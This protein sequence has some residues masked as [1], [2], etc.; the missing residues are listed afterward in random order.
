M[1]KSALKIAGLTQK[2]LLDL[3]ARR[4]QIQKRLGKTT[5][6]SQW[7]DKT[8][9]PV[10]D[11]AKLTDAEWA[12]MDQIGLYF[13]A[14]TFLKRKA[15]VEALVSNVAS[16]K[17]AMEEAGASEEEIASSTKAA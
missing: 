6:Q 1:N 3:F 11:R 9:I 12:V 7:V 5:A 4:G 16:T 15:K 2:A 8:S 10:E 17:A 13:A 14:V